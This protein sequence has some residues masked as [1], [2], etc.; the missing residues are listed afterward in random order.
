MIIVTLTI[1]DARELAA[2]ERARVAHNAMLTDGAGL[3]PVDPAGSCADAETY[4]R[5]V[6]ALAVESWAVQHVDQ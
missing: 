1:T 3:W 6:A 2:I 4:I 5:K